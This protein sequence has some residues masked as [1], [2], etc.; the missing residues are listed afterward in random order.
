MTVNEIKVK[1][2]IIEVDVNKYDKYDIYV[3]DDKDHFLYSITN[4]E[5]IN[6]NSH[7]EELEEW[8]IDGEHN[9][10]NLQD[11]FKKLISRVEINCNTLF[12]NN[13]AFEFDDK[14]IEYDEDLRVI[15]V[16]QNGNKLFSL[17]G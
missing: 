11:Y 6:L 15:N 13:K 17:E 14:L 12:N 4:I 2:F 8:L 3:W 7:L 1:N 10:I 9:P 16:Y 5:L